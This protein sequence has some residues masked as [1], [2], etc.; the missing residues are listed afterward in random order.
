[1]L[2][3]LQAGMPLSNLPFIVAAFAVTGIGFLAYGIF[4]FRRRQ[5]LR[6]EIRE[7]EDAAVADRAG[8]SGQ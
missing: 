7:L 8:E 6:R 1:M 2:V 4:L 3:L 5:D